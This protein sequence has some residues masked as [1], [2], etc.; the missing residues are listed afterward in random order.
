MVYDTY[1]ICYTIHRNCGR[2]TPRVMTD[3]FVV[4]KPSKSDWM[5]MNICRNVKKNVVYKP[6]G[7]PGLETGH[8]N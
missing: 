7:L 6:G 4:T 1:D 3:H 5:L 8:D 2:P